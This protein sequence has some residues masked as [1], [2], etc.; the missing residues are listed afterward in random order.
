MVANYFKIN[1]KSTA[2]KPLAIFVLFIYCSLVLS[3]NPL[4]HSYS[5]DLN[6]NPI[7]SGVCSSSVYLLSSPVRL[8]ISSY[9]LNKL[10]KLTLFKKSATTQI[11]SIAPLYLITPIEHL[12][13]YLTKI[14][15]CHSLAPPKA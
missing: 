8:S 12:T 13:T 4:P 11:F 5:W 14:S 10:S 9:S 3:L 1:T 15:S 6:K 2:L 7:I